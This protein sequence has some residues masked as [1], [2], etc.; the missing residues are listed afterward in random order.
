MFNIFRWEGLLGGDVQ[1]INPEE[2]FKKLSD[3]KGNNA[4]VIDVR[5]P[6]E[7]NGKLGH[8]ENAKLI[9]IRLLP[10]K[11]K[12]LE[13]YKNKEIIAVCHS[14]ARS[15]SAAAMLKRHGFEN[16]YNLKGGM[17]LWK[18]TGLKTSI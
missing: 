1:Q 7:F 12:E 9:P 16:V 6:Q 3:S 11:V 17:L 5:E 2:A 10:L 18:K 15:Y 8:I 14:G 4:I 13:Q